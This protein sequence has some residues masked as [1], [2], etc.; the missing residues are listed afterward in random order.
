MLISHSVDGVTKFWDLNSGKEV[1]E[2]IHFGEKEWMVKNPSGFFNG[3]E[4]AHKY[5][6]FVNEIKTYSVNQFF[7][8]F[9]RPELLSKIFLNRGGDDQY[10]GI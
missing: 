10:I 1:F 5:I 4:E 8:E 6:H 3:T 9:Y 2:H 7:D